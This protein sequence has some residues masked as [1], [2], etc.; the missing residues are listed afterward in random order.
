MSHRFIGLAV[1]L[2][3]FV[4]PPAAAQDVD[5]SFVLVRLIH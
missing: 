4:P 3:L 2:V 1:A 5:L